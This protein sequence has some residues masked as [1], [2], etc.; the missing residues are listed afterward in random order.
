M[1]MSVEQLSRIIGAC[2]L[3]Q[4]QPQHISQLVYDSRRI[5]AP[6]Q[7]VFFALRTTAADGENY[8]HHAYQAG[9]R[10]FVVHPGFSS[11]T[12]LPEA[13]LLEVPDT[14]LAMQQLARWQRLQS[15]AHIIGITGSNGKTIVKDWLSWLMQPDFR[16]CRSP[17][18]YNSQLGVPLSVWQLRPDDQY[19]IFEAGISA[20]GEM[21]RLADIIRPDTGIFTHLGDAHAEF[22]SDRST[23]LAEKFLLFAGV[24]RLVLRTDDEALAQAAAALQQSQPDMEVIAW[25]SQRETTYKLLEA[26]VGKDKTSL[27]L[28]SLQGESTLE[29]P[30]SDAASI[31]NAMHCWVLLKH[32]GYAD[33]VLQ[34]RFARLPRLQ[35]R[36]EMKAA[37][38]GSTLINDSYSLDLDSLS[39]ALQQLKSL[40]QYHRRLLILSD[41]DVQNQAKGQLY[42]ELARLLAPYHLNRIYA[43]GPDLHAHAHCFKATELVFFKDTDHFL[44]ELPMDELANAAILLKGAR[45]FGFEKIDRLLSLKLHQT[46]LEID[47]DAML[48]NYRYFRGL[49]KPETKIMGMV[50]A[51]S[52]G[53]GSVEVASLLQNQRADYLA[54]A[55]ADEGVLLREAGIKLPIMVMNV[56][57]GG[58]DKLLAYQLEPELYS[59]RLLDEL[60]H[61]LERNPTEQNL[62]LHI[63]IDTG[64]KRLGFAPTQM[65]ELA[66]RLNAHPRLQLASAYSHLVGSDAPEHADFTR[67]QIMSFET[68]YEELSRLTNSRPLKH[69]LNT[70]GV[71]HF[72][73][74]QFDMVRLGIGLYGFDPAAG[75]AQQQLQP[76]GT[77]KTIVSQIHELQPDETVGYNRSGKAVRPTRVATLPVGYADGIVRACGNGRVRFYVNGKLAPTIGSICMD[78]CMLDITGIGCSEGDTVIIFG[79][80]NPISRLADALNT[81]PY[82]ILTNVSQRVK[83][84][85]LKD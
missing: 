82:E 44:R 80:E 74:A 16:V 55:F 42:S 79:N 85:Y 38:H 12:A 61:W 17:K 47:L 67:Q 51:F 39:I 11:A 31:E 70:A 45:K 53:S 18:S 60:L 34:E 63:N 78:M 19:G 62:A 7:S 73:D 49:L 33:G 23:K 1:Y 69:I 64:M 41:F 30:F 72:P 37:L 32:M 77:L 8:I 3:Q 26:T 68:A 48:H 24:S 10:S 56:E 52:Y 54:V 20:P 9:I 4:A 59:F 75:A 57:P 81:I 13:N 14:L 6:A 58:I 35:M 71:L 27:Q 22:F 21:A 46:V 25:S 65:A 36:L 5:S 66:H 28:R 29:L 2:W 76:V 43:V 84:V 40:P 15:R 83:R 50:K